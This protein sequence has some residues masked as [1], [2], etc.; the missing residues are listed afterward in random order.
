MRNLDIITQ[1]RN[2]SWKFTKNILTYLFLIILSIICFI[3][4]YIMIIN[5]THS[6]VE[7]NNGLNLLPGR[8]LLDNYKR[9]SESI[10]IWKGFS[11]SLLISIVSTLLTAYFASL[12]AYGFAKFKFRGNKVLYWF[13]LSTMM[14]PGQLG[15]IGYFQLNKKLGLLDTYLPLILPAIA[16]GNAVFWINSYIGSSISNSLIESARIDGCQELKIFNKII[17]PL[18]VPAIAT[19]SIFNFV[20]SWN[21]FMRPLVLIFSPSKF[22]LPVLVANLRGTYTRDFGATYLGIAISVV[23]I[24]IAYVFLSRYILNGLTIGAVKE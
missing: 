21:D 2:R 19:I 20:A 17:L 9:M 12:T 10:N 6:N 11:N 5:A 8:Y 13:V 7:I 1:N 22:T 14:V 24:M 23:P 16:N 15:L 18:I 4:F 3:P